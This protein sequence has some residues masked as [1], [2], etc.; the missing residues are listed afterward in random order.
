MCKERRREPAWVA[1]IRL[2]LLEGRATV[3]GVMEEANLADGRE[4][5][6]IDVLETMADRDLLVPVADGEAYVA[7]ESLRSSAPSPE[8]AS[9]ASDDGIHRWKRAP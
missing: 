6:V 8:A 9:R 3:E 5:T 7:G 2:A 1:A 4:R